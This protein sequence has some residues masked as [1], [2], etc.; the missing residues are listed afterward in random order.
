MTEELAVVDQLAVILA[1]SVQSENT[2]RS[3]LKSLNAYREFIRK[4]GYEETIDRDMVTRWRNSM[5]AAGA[6]ASTVNVRMSGLKCLIRELQTR[7]ALDGAEAC[8]GVK[9]VKSRGVRTGNWL[10]DEQAMRLMNA[11]PSD[12]NIGVRDRAIL[13]MLLGVGLRREEC[14]S[15]TIE[16]LAV[17][18][19]CRIIR[20]LIGKAGRVRSLALPTLVDERLQL[21]IDRANISSGPIFRSVD[22]FGHIGESI[23]DDGIRSVVERRS[24]E[25]GIPIAA[26]DCRRSYAAMC[27]AGGAP[28]EAIQAALGHAEIGTTS[29]YLDKCFDPAKSAGTFIGI[30]QAGVRL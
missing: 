28:L 22:Q 9:G 8:L 23:S 4:N 27:R 30:M 7:E 15:L 19:G 2:R 26:H 3:Y 21:W 20:N 1:E 11:P 25:I 5:T 14:A 29:K 13:A 16:H 24:R 10:N 17:Q 12:T 6:S 18:D